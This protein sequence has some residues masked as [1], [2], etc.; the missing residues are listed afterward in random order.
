MAPA[1]AASTQRRSSGSNQ[2]SMALSLPDSSSPESSSPESISPESIHA[3]IT[4]L[5]LHHSHQDADF[6]SRLL[7]TIFQQLVVDTNALN[8]VAYLTVLRTY[9]SRAACPVLPN[10]LRETFI[11]ALGA[12]VQT[13][14]N[15]FWSGALR[16]T[17]QHNNHCVRTCT[18]QLLGELATHLPNAVCPL[19]QQLVCDANVMVAR[20]AVRVFA[21]IHDWP[22]IDFR[23]DFVAALLTVH[24]GRA[25][26]NLAHKEDRTFVYAILNTSTLPNFTAFAMVVT[27][28]QTCLHRFSATSIS[29]DETQLC[30]CLEAVKERHPHFNSVLRTSLRARRHKQFGHV[31]GA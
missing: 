6:I 12:S 2:M 5:L 30:A 26:T 24:G 16:F 25:A 11:V 3:S 19:L 7:Q 21:R 14:D 27:F 18:A 22:I 10:L 8:V 1:V 13:A 9:L 28:F 31:R 4:P 23:P 20:K 29:D 15:L 17:S